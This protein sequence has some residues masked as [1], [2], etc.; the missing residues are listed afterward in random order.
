MSEQENMNQN[1]E[2]M[3][4]EIMINQEDG[5]GQDMYAFEIEVN[6]EPYIIIIGKT[7]ENKIF[8]RLMDKEDQSKP[9]FQNEFSLDDLRNINPI[10]NGID[11]EDLAFQ[12]LAS[13][14]N[15][16]EKDIKN[17]DE[18][19][20]IF[21]IIITDED[22]KIEFEFPLYKAIDDGGENEMNENMENEM[23]EGE[24]EMIGINDLNELHQVNEV[25]EPNGESGHKEKNIP[26]QIEEKKEE[27]KESKKKEITPTNLIE[28][29]KEKEE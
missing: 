23:E 10:F 6:D 3:D 22:E 8:L 2:E 7:D 12:Y 19:K 15:D 16:A 17:I 27:I 1:E 5:E 18:E 20:I 28:T 4:E 9:F 11:R 25:N 14:L 29:K 24:E 13:N 21:G 26:V